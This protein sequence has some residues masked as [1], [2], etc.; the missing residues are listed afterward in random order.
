[1]GR[2]VEEG[3]GRLR[4][5]KAGGG[6]EGEEGTDSSNTLDRRTSST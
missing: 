2:E 1:M 5:G 6:R 4:E 3:E